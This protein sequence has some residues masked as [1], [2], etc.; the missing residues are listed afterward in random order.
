MDL[1]SVRYRKEPEGGEV[2][3]LLTYNTRDI[4]SGKDYDK[5]QG[6]PVLNYLKESDADIICLQE[7]AS[8]WKVNQKKLIGLCLLILIIEWYGLRE[9]VGYHVILVI[10]FY[11]HSAWIIRVN[12][13]G[14]YYIV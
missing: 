5:E 14:V 2:I 6:N 11:R 13:T 3:K 7:F 4:A 8:N 9:E 12:L 10:L 1:L